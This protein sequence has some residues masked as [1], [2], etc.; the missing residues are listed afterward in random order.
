[1]PFAIC[2]LPLATASPALQNSMHPEVWNKRCDLENA[3]APATLDPWDGANVASSPVVCQ[4]PFPIGLGSNST[5]I[6]DLCQH[7]PMVPGAVKNKSGINEGTFHQICLK[8]LYQ[9]SSLSLIST[10]EKTQHCSITTC[11]WPKSWRTLHKN[12][13][14]SSEA[15]PYAMTA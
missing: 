1:M 4:H 6:L 10:L 5:R 7:R 8:I 15:W 14:S 2:H 13:S 11:G 9:K 3:P 12:R